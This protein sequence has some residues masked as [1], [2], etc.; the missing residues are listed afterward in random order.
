MREIKTYFKGAPFYNA[1]LRT[2]PVQ[3][4]AGIVSE[5]NVYRDY[6]LFHALSS[7]ALPSRNS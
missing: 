4:R 7:W 3:V 6:R 5:C 1:F 2:Y